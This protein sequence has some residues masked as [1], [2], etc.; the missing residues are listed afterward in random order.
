M[1]DKKLINVA[2]VGVG[3]CASSLIQGFGYYRDTANIP[4]VML[5][6]IGGYFPGDIQVVAAFDVDH[7][8]I[9]RPLSAAIFEKPNCTMEFS[10]Q[11]TL[12]MALHTDPVVRP[13]P[14]MDGVAAHM[15][16]WPVD[17]SFRDYRWAYSQGLITDK[18]MSHLENLIDRKAIIAHLKSV[19]TDMVINYLPVGSQQ[20]T[21]FWAEICLEAG[22]SFLNCIPV[23]IASDPAWEKRFFD[24]G[25]PIVGDD[26]RSQF[27]ASIV[28]AVLQELALIRGHEIDVHIQQ[29]SGGNTDFLNMIDKDRL[30][31]KKIS[32]TNVITSQSTLQG[33]TDKPNSIH[34][35][36]SE[37]IRYYGDNKV[38][39]FRLELKGFGGAP[40]IFDAR[41]S[42]QDSPNSAG[43][44]IDAI[45]YLKV[46]REMGIAG[47]LRGPSAFTQKTPPEQMVTSEAR[48]ECLAL[49]GRQLTDRTRKQ[50]RPVS[51]YGVRLPNSMQARGDFDHIRIPAALKESGRQPVYK[52]PEQL[53]HLELAVRDGLL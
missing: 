10:N 43:V 22:I 3:N 44:V 48:E 16:N 53:S 17:D 36:P 4:G 11:E 23:F 42:V 37:Y 12:E 20:A 51:A 35:G 34:A 38:A 1:T 50:V 28:S 52:Q 14:I 7:R 49:A 39:T 5:H 33:Y 21:E 31:S 27:G 47:S 30:V 46:A 41:L 25:I 32:K 18:A 6:D 45:R 8:K 29:N 19:N 13:A 24:A 15:Y 40:V 9:G 26:M 2:I